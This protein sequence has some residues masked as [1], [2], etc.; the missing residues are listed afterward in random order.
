MLYLIYNDTYNSGLLKEKDAKNLCK[1][2]N[3]INLQVICYYKGKIVA[4]EKP[5]TIWN[6]QKPQ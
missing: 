2:N 5:E 1:S 3:M 6:I 4:R